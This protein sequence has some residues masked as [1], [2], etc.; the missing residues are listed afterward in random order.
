MIGIQI[1]Y[2]NTY[3][4]FCDSRDAAFQ[5]SCDLCLTIKVIFLAR[6]LKLIFY[7]LFDYITLIYH[8][9]ILF[10]LFAVKY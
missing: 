6:T 8:S 1:W 10:H 9:C 7:G 2:N 3:S 5:V 4:D